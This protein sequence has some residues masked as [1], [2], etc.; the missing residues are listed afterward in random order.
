MSTR[1]KGAAPP[2][3][4]YNQLLQA[5]LEQCRIRPQGPAALPGV[6]CWRLDP[7]PSPCPG[8]EEEDGA[9]SFFTLV[10]GQRDASIL[11]APW[12]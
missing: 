7:P 4:G 3:G 12:C 2:P 10:L 8:D 9:R 5:T 1:G 6:R 11:P